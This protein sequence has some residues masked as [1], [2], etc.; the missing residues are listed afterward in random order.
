MKI[1]AKGCLELGNC[2][3]E[4][5]SRLHALLDKFSLGEMCGYDCFDY[6]DLIDAMLLD[7][8]RDGE[9]MS[10]IMLGEIGRCFIETMS[11]AKAVNILRLG[12]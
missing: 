9:N 5:Y 8:K 3:G 7:K 4:D 10:L 2:S 1:V 11:I 12:L 6:E